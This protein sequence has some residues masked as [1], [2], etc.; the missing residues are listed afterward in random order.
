MADGKRRSFLGIFEDKPT[1]MRLLFLILL[2]PSFLYSQRTSFNYSNKEW[3]PSEFPA[4]ITNVKA[5]E[6]KVKKS[7]KVKR[8]STLL[9]DQTYDDVKHTVSG[10]NYSESFMIG[11]NDKVSSERHYHRFINKYNCN[12]K[13]IYQSIRPLT[14]ISREKSSEFD[15]NNTEIFNEFDNNDNLTTEE[16]RYTKADYTLAYK[17][18]D[19][20]Y[21][22]VSTN[23]SF[24]YYSYENNKCIADY[25]Y[26]DSTKTTYTSNFIDKTLEQKS[27]CYGCHTKY[28]NVERKYDTK[29][30]NFLETTYTREGEIHTKRYY[31]YDD[32]ARI[33]KEIDS[34]GWYLNKTEPYKKSETTYTYTNQ[35]RTKTK[36]DYKTTFSSYKKTVIIY[37][38]ED[39]ILSECTTRDDSTENCEY[40]QYIYNNNLISE[41]IQTDCNGKKVISYF[42]YNGSGLRTEERDTFEGKIYKL[43]R[44]FYE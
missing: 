19:T 6:Y 35:G 2:I 24:Y 28:K 14:N 4:G 20:I 31:F 44:Y 22:S 18:K 40:T 5:Y 17:G 25:I 9:Y 34:T 33:V 27:Y 15:L 32:N 26:K 42:K 11:Y 41:I 8:D 38:A 39:N 36:I 13:L 1:D 16:T 7:G 23:S 29:N 21:S 12:G 3:R 37:N 10:R 43:V 30:L